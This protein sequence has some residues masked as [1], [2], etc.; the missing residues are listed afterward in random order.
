MTGS[1]APRIV[2]TER[3]TVPPGEQLISFE[4]PVDVEDGRWVVLR[5][6]DPTQP[7]DDRAPA[8]YGASGGG[9]AYASPFFLEP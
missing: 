4:A 8:E 7:A 9:I 5:L 2:H 3:I 6:T 1:P